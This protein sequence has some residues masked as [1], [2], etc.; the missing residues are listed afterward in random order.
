MRHHPAGVRDDPR[1]VPGAIFGLAV[2]RPSGRRPATLAHAAEFGW[3]APPLLKRDEGVEHYGCDAK[4]Q[5]HLPKAAALR[6]DDG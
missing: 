4:E 6:P 3:P 1:R 5:G 2:T